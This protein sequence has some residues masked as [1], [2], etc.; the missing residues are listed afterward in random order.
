MASNFPKLPG[1]VPTHDPTLVDHKKISHKKLEEIRNGKNV[2]VPLYE[3]PNKPAPTGGAA[4]FA[5]KTRG[6]LGQK[7]EEN[8]SYSQTIF[9]NH[10]NGGQDVAELFE[11]TFVK[12]DK[13][14]RRPSLNSLIN[15]L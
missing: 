15:L 6:D 12:L 13:Q 11:P 14:V 7:P 8:K 2:K 4:A 10:F 5:A 3:M 9:K 1:L